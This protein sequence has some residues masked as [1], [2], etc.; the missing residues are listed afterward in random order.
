MSQRSKLLTVTAIA[1]LLLGTG[2]SKTDNTNNTKTN[3]T[4]K[5]KE[6]ETET[7]VSVGNHLGTI[8]YKLLPNWKNEGYCEFIANE[9]SYDEQEGIIKICNEKEDKGNP[10]FNY[11]K[12][13]LFT[14]H[15]FQER[16]I[17]IE[18][19]LNDDVDLGTLNGAL[20]DKYC[21]QHSINTKPINR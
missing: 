2:C 5:E 16:N 20:K 21:T 14:T 15:L 18:K 4:E 10:S 17:S 7:T 6:K 13:R 11:F 12:Y 9:S 8:K 1:F 19:F 3:S